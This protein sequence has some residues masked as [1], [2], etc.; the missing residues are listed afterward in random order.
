MSQTIEE[1]ITCQARSYQLFLDL[2]IYRLD[3]WWEIGGIS[4]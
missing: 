2:R 3:E 4:E 1:L